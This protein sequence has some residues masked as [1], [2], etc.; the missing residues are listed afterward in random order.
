[1]VPSFTSNPCLLLLRAVAPGDDPDLGGN[2][3]AWQRFLPTGPLALLPLTPSSSC[4]I[5]STTHAQELLALSEE[6]MGEEVNRALWSEEGKDPLV[7]YLGGL[8][9]EAVQGLRTYSS[10]Y[11]TLNLR[12]FFI[13][14][15][16]HWRSPV[17]NHR[18]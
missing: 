8:I 7:G 17:K 18:D 11:Q 16:N 14:I 1:M 9:D 5:W 15:V 6:Q 12:Q 2:D 4:L 13:M 3:T 10:L